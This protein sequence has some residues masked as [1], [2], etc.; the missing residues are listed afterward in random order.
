MPNQVA[1]L[2]CHPPWSCFQWLI[3]STH[4]EFHVGTSFRKVW[5]LDGKFSHLISGFSS[6]PS[7]TGL[8]VSPVTIIPGGG[9]VGIGPATDAISVQTNLVHSPGF[10][11]VEETKEYFLLMVEKG[12]GGGGEQRYIRNRFLI[13]ALVFWGR[14]GCLFNHLVTKADWSVF[15]WSPENLQIH[16]QLFNRGN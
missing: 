11:F 14:W 3:K 12:R 13:D 7:S 5:T 15:L 8:V 9:E 1:T 2:G 10:W 4:F 6:V 16:Y